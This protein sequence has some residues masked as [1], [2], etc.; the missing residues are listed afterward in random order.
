M[1]MQRKRFLCELNFL[2]VWFIFFLKHGIIK[3]KDG[4]KSMISLNE[5]EKKLRQHEKELR[6]K[7]GIEEIG[8]FGSYVRGEQKEGS[9]LDIL[10]SFKEK[11]KTDLIAF[12]ELE[13]YLS[14]LLGVKVDLV[15]KSALKPRIGKQILKEVVY[16]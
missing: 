9:D 13:E 2:S 6:E 14:E 10:V 12:V 8:I 7:Y 1:K 4:E 11:F 5:I 3:A 15:M 16:L